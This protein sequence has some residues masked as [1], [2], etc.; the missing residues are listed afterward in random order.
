MQRMTG[1]TSKPHC[2]AY[3]VLAVVVGLSASGAFAGDSA[4]SLTI[5]PGE[6]Q[7][8][9]TENGVKPFLDGFG[10][11]LVPGT[12]TLP[13][14]IFAIAVPA[15]AQVQAIDVEMGEG[16]LLPG[17]FDIA[18]A[19][20]PRVIGQ[21]DPTVY[22]REKATYDSNF[23]AVYESADAYPKL[24]AELVRT[25]GYRKYNLADVRVTPF[26][27]RPL[28]GELTYYPNVTVHVQYD[29]PD[30]AR[31]AIID[32]LPRTER[33]AREIIANYDEVSDWYP[34]SARAGRGLHDYVIVTTDSLAS[35]VTSLVD[36]ET[37]KGRTVEVVTTSWIN[38]NYSGYD[39]AE[40]IRNFL[41]DKYPSGE[42]GIED[43]LLVGHYDQ[44]PMRRTAQD[45]G[46]GRPETDFYYAELSQADSDSWDSDGD[47]QYGEYS[48]SID[49]YAEVN[50]GRIPWSDRD[51]VQHI[52][53]KSVAYE[54]NGDP[55]YKKNMLLLAAYFWAN[56]DNAELMEEKTAQP[57]LADW[58]FTK[59]YEK[60]GDYWSS[61][62]CDYPLTRAN[63]QSVW[64]NGQFAFVNWAGHGSPTSTHIYGLGGTA[65]VNS[66]DCG[67][68]N[69]D[70]PAVIFADACSNSDT[71]ET[72]IGQEMLRQ[73][74][75]GFVG[76][77]KVAYGCSGWNSPYD[78]SSQSLDY[79]FTSYVTS[80]DYTQGAALQRAMREMY[81]N[82][83]WYYTK[84]ETFEW[85]A[86]W[87]NPNLSMDIPDVS[88]PIAVG[89]PKNRYVSFGP[90][91]GGMWTAYQV[92]LTDS[93]YFP[94]SRGVLGW[95]GEPD[96]DGI[97]SIVAEPYFTGDWPE[98]VHVG[99]C[100]IVPAAVYEVRASGDGVM[101]TNALELP[102]ITSP[103]GK[104][105][106]DC[107]G[108]FIGEWSWPDGNVTMDDIMAAVQVF[109]AAP[110]APHVTCVDVD[111][112]EPNKV[113]NM[114]DIMRIAQ[115]FGGEPYPFCDPGACP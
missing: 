44:V 106:C 20:L 73:G 56:T 105:W 90:N 45:E 22:A 28:R 41:R 101:L 91:S 79:F 89:G 6:C 64:R 104:Y 50:V 31:A 5:S 100:R 72:N 66:Y 74:A 102:T 14:R 88:A 25:A 35:S 85:G 80:G 27:Y 43:V 103:N 39:T 34:R 77:T 53:E 107:V 115:G 47:R 86:L 75:V 46:Y 59:L 24:A 37:Y 26:A 70:Y 52:C 7:I 17:A 12:P 71:D 19:P 60:N 93:E 98:V 96:A 8:I 112:Q 48:D 110:S 83:L 1:C 4:V 63:V 10:Y 18:P 15:G 9:D 113:V 76:A 33:I 62:A 21:E 2:R 94:E 78:G 55:T 114:T 42:W 67:F 16:V 54:Q 65:F 69:D 29:L 108:P 92:E 38:S 32:D 30:T 87:G 109:Q 51:T 57:W 95:V 3:W 99:D 58:T 84:Y 81:T 11:S 36:W 111:A 23:T 13:S 40:R 49:Y 82:G 61:Y 68:L 97:A